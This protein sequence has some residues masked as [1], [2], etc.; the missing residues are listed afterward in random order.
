MPPILPFSIGKAGRPSNSVS[1]T[2]LHCDSI[3]IIHSYGS[4]VNIFK[5]RQKPSSLSLM[6]LFSLTYS[7]NIDYYSVLLLRKN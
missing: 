3:Y 2:V 4:T 6:D 5:T 1:T 7:F